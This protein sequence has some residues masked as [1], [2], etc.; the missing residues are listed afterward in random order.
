VNE[1]ASRP[2]DPPPGHR[3]GYWE[4]HELFHAHASALFGGDPAE[5]RRL[6]EL[7]HA[8]HA[9]AHQV[10][11]FA[12]FTTCV[13]EHFGDELDWAALGAFME[14]VRAACPDVSPLKT[15]ALIRACF[16]ETRLLMEVPQREHAAS[17]WA[18]CRLVVG[19]HRGEDELASLYGRAEGFGRKAVREV[20]ASPQLRAWCEKPADDAEPPGRPDDAPA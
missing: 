11:V 4:R 6:G 5:C 3:T 19:E 15:E 20:F 2:A 8:D 16:G 18:V 12:L 7:I 10:F 13:N 9:L 1:G 14:R 17:M